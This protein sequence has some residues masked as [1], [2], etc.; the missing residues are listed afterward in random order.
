ME[1]NALAKCATGAIIGKLFQAETKS[2]T[3]FGARL[4]GLLNII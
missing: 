4:M 3:Y 2:P 1:E